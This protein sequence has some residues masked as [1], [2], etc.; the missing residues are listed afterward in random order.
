MFDSSLFSKP[1]LSAKIDL[2]STILIS[3]E[4][5]FYV[6]QNSVDF[7]EKNILNADSTKIPRK[8]MTVDPPPLSE[9]NPSSGLAFVSSTKFP[10]K[11]NCLYQ[12]KTWLREPWFWTLH[13]TADGVEIPKNALTIAFS[14][15]SYASFGVNCEENS[16]FEGLILKLTTLYWIDWKDIDFVPSV[17]ILT[18]W[19]IQTCYHSRI[20]PTTKHTSPHK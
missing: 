2:T 1:K 3:I 20:L 9:T 14:R 10:N 19:D 4:N 11:I 5:F 17:K 18:V 12:S 7:F 15:N 6:E 13:E 16:S 8:A